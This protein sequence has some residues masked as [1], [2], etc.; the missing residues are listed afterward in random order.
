MS[1]AQQTLA[2]ADEPVGDPACPAGGGVADTEGMSIEAWWPKLRPESRDYLIANNG[3]VVPAR[4]VEEIA[5]VGGAIAT[6]A[7]W[8]GRADPTGLYLSDEGIDW[9]D[10]F[11]NGETPLPHDEGPPVTRVG[12]NP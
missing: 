2:R 10:E 5:G 9:I 6:D 8:V 11:A 7:W 3:N 12:L 1:A 4:L